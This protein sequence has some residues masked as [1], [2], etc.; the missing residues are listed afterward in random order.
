LPACV[1]LVPASALAEVARLSRANAPA[2]FLDAGGVAY[3]WRLLSIFFPNDLTP[4]LVE[5]CNPGLVFAMGSSERGSQQAGYQIGWR[6]CQ[7]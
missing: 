5:V 7:S 1:V 4:D 2:V 6:L 3:P